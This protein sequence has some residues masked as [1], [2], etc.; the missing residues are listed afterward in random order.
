MD[1]KNDLSGSDN[2]DDE[3]MSPVDLKKMNIGAKKTNRN[4]VSAEAFGTFN[5]K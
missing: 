2:D 4:S 1:K 3:I 5:K